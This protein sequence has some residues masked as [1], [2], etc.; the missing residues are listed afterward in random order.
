M[1]GH[2]GPA[3][4][5]ELGLDWAQWLDTQRRN[6]VWVGLASRHLP[7]PRWSNDDRVEVVSEAFAR[8]VY[9]VARGD[10]VKNPGGWI[11]QTIVRLCID[12]R[13]RAQSGLEVEADQETIADPAPATFPG[14]GLA[15]D[16]F[17]ALDDLVARGVVS[18]QSRLL[19]R[20]HYEHG[21]EEA[22]LARQLGVTRA[23]VCDRL[24]RVRRH[25]VGHPR[26]RGLDEHGE[27]TDGHCDGA[28]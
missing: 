1:Q 20:L 18:D 21:V 9:V 28:S 15:W 17:V 8:L 22:E 2:G 3:S 14:D 24:R 23:S 4:R 6:P 10:R 16:L 11:H 27:C 13:R 5:P 25:L 12:C 26:L 7:S 19:F